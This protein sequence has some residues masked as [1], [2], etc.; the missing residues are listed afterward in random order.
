MSRCS[1]RKTKPKDNHL[2]HCKEKRSKRLCVDQS[3]TIASRYHLGIYDSLTLSHEVEV[4]K[5]TIVQN[6]SRTSS[7][8]GSQ[9]IL[10]TVTYV[11]KGTQIVECVYGSIGMIDDPCNGCTHVLNRGC[12]DRT[13]PGGEL[14]IDSN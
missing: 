4:I 1:T 5:H 13:A 10:H 8:C 9:R 14:S 7:F 6:V 2:H 12:I 3:S 11:C